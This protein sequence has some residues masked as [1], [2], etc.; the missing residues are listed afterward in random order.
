MERNL[1]LG[2][3][4]AAFFFVLARAFW[5]LMQHLLQ[6][7]LV[8]RQTANSTGSLGD[9]VLSWAVWGPLS[10]AVP[11]VQTAG[12]PSLLLKIMAIMAL[13]HQAR[14]VVQQEMIQHLP[15][16]P[17]LR[18]LPLLRPP[19]LLRPLLRHR[20]HHRRLFVVII[21]VVI[22]WSIAEAGRRI[23]CG[24]ACA[25][26]SPFIHS[27]HSRFRNGLKIIQFVS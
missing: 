11:V 18:P 1:N 5:V 7:T 27:L 14:Q 15:Q 12:N 8:E 21:V 17:R 9:Y 20:H 26:S 6:V 19:P 3:L 25:L 23:G 16:R 4:A 10:M 2:V 24:K 13:S 22:P